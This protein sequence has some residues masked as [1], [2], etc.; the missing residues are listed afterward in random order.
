LKIDV[1]G[2][3]TFYS[4]GNGWFAP[5]QPS[6][7]FIHGAGMD[8]SVWTLPARH[9]ARHGYNVVAP[10]L[11]GHGRSAGPQLT[12]IEA[13]AQWLQHLL[14][15]LTI[16]Q[17]TM[18]GHSMGSLAALAFAARQPN[19]TRTLALLGTSAPMPVTDVLLDAAR[20]NDH[21]A[22]DMANTW[23]HSSF[24]LQGGNANPGINMMMSG[25]RL[26]ERA[27][28]D[29]FYTDLNACNSFTE[30]DV[31]AAEITVPTMVIAGDEDKMTTAARGAE[32]ARLIRNAELVHL[33]SCGHS[34]LSE[35]PN[36]VLDALR[37]IV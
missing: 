23:S 28:D 17:A 16:D 5:D 21:D 1:V 30:G 2:K 33:S 18:V 6:V 34:M 3:R 32:V 31:L 26:I 9:F 13:M 10:D 7:V 20:A 8:H 29:V 11:P 14:D 15:A 25:Q 12:S 36:E 24:G 19:R 37:E 22:I 4:N 35:R 27:A